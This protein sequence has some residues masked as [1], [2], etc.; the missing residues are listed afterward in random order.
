MKKFEY[1]LVIVQT[2]NHSAMP[3]IN[4][5]GQEGWE[6]VTVS[7]KDEFI[8]KREIIDTTMI[9]EFSFKPVK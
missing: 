4:K 2:S 5:I 7:D 1:K 3:Y 6:L 9:D 8:F